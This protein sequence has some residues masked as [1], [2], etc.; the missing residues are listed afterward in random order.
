[1]NM[2]SNLRTMIS[3]WSTSGALNNMDSEMLSDIGLD[4]YDVL[5]SRKFRGVRR[6]SF[7]AERR[8]SRATNWLR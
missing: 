6:A 7:L 1:M 4:R 2:F 3:G 5:E 8:Q